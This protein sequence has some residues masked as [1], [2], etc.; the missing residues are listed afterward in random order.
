VFYSN[1]TSAFSL[2]ARIAARPVTWIHHHHGD[3]TVSILERFSLLYRATLRTADWLIL[4][5]DG[6]AKLI[7]QT[8]RRVGGTV[9][10]PYLKDEQTAAPSISEKGPGDKVVV[11][12]FGRLRQSKGVGLLLSSATWFSSHGIECRLHGDNC[13]NLISGDLPDGITWRGAYDSATDLSRLMADVDM[14]VLPSTFG[15]GLPIVM[16]EAISRGVPVVCFPAGGLR[17]METFHPGV[18]VVPPTS[19]DL[20]AGMLEMLK[21]SQRPGFSEELA[22]RYKEQLSNGVTIDWWFDL[23]K[24]V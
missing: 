11:G 14:V 16:C 21:R 6:H 23:L 10:L 1:G 5:T 2:L 4:C 22:A 8:Y 9:A 17:E 7:R 13:E 18:L 3:I 12:F 20:V 15:E 19:E 24:R